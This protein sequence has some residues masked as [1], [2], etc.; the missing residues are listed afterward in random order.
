MRSLSNLAKVGK[1]FI[2]RHQHQANFK[3]SW[4]LFAEGTWRS[5]KTGLV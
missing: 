1:K 2:L 5:Y 4:L 3:Q